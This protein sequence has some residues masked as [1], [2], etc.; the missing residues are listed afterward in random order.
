MT[1]NRNNIIQ[2]RPRKPE[3][4]PKKPKNP[5]PWLQNRM[6][7]IFVGLVIC[8]FIA[9]NYLQQKPTEQTLQFAVLGD[10]AFGN[11]T[12]DSSSY[13]YVSD[14]LDNNPGITH[15]VFQDMPGT[16]DGQTN[17]E[18]ARLIRDRGISVHLQSDSY[19][20][21]GAVDLFIGGQKRTMDC[22]A[23][24]GVHS[25]RTAPGVTADSL[26]R[27][28]L[29]TNHERFLKDMGID[30]AFYQFT[31]DSAAPN[32]IYVLSDAEIERFGLLTL[33]ANCS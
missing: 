5:N 15:M 32:E 4:K 7:Y 14:L 31:Q 8:G 18:I 16:V 26:G 17:L 30:K 23:R 27:D 20:A 1:Q 12:T 13:R 25:W 33:P 11:G 28:P 21:S 24:I 19:I 29:R 22:G 3:P 10:T 2:F 6:G 9:V